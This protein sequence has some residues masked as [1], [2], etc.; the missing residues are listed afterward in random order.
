MLHKL[1]EGNSSEKRVRKITTLDLN[2]AQCFIPS[3]QTPKCDQPVV[4]IP[5]LHTMFQDFL[6]DII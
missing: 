5:K 6:Q 4:H 3:P 2:E 1:E